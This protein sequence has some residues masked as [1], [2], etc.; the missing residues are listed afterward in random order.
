MGDVILQE[1]HI[2]TL[3][4]SEVEEAYESTR[5]ESLQRPFRITFLV[6]T[7]LGVVFAYLYMNNVLIMGKAI[8]TLLYYYIL[9]ALFGSCAYLILPA[10][11]KAK[12]KLP[13]Y[14]IV[15]SIVALALPLYFSTRHFEIGTVGWIP[16]PTTFTLVLA[17]IYALLILELC[18]RMGGWVFFVLCIILGTFPLYADKGAGVFFGISYDFKYVISYM[19]YGSEGIIGL[20][21]MILGKIIIGF[22]IFAG[23][24][25]ATGAG[26]FF[27]NLSFALMGKYRGGSAKVAVVSS[28]F[29]GSL[30][31]SPVSNVVSTGTI[32]IPAMK[33]TGYSRHYAG[34]IEAVASTGGVLL[35]PVMGAIV[36]VM[37]V[38]TGYSYAEIM[39]AAI[40]PAI[41][42]FFG[43]LIQVDFYAGKKGLKGMAKPD[44]PAFKKTLKEGWHFIF[45]VLFLL[46]GLL[47]MRWGEVAPYHA[48]LVLIIL[49]YMNKSTRL[50]FAKFV[51][52]LEI[53]GKLICQMVALMLPFT[54]VL[55]GL[56]LTG[57]AASF[58][59]GLVNLGGG[60]VFYILLLGVLAC[61]ILG[62]IGFDLAA[63]IFLSVSMAPALVQLGLNK[64][65]V[66]LFIV[67][68]PML[69]VITPPIAIAAF[70]AAGIAG[71]PPMKTAWTS[72]RL[73]VVI[74]FIPMFFVFQ[75]ALVMQGTPG[76][77]IFYTLMCMIG[78]TIMCG[79]L[80][81]YFYKVGIIKNWIARMTFI[82]AGFMIAFPSSATSIIGAVVFIGVYL[83]LMSNKKSKLVSE[84]IVE[85]S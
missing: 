82:V 5:L 9:F 15:F 55:A 16:A 27:L 28:A 13:W 81:G 36:F 71:A 44:I 17:I 75:P 76:D 26:E 43:L 38:I 33:K 84:S 68:Y 78:I 21:G 77:I 12:T 31:G 80:E 42:Y 64:M 53:I 41:L 24:L 25:I 65:A 11:K 52:S 34:A 30:S 29:F 54:F 8:P 7:F 20:P 4:A 85:H 58:A 73:G 56:V 60:N 37:A 74:Y 61:Y 79:G 19:I 46:Y 59:N 45:V 2:K 40:I 50:T 14:D 67:Y 10:W 66:H 49:S 51:K 83:V 57:V 23:L 22:L 35:P 48:S 32:T 18:R 62:A 70:V 6:F 63:Y 39:I 69:A 47:I 3:D 1:D 72:M